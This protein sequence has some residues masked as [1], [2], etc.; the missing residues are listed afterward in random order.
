MI[1]TILHCLLWA[2]KL[3][4]D[5]ADIPR[6]NKS[7]L[8]KIYEC[9]NKSMALLHGSMF[10]Q[11]ISNLLDQQANNEK[12]QRKT[13]E[14]FNARLKEDWTN[15]NDVSVPSSP[16]PIESNRSTLFDEDSPVSSANRSIIRHH[17]EIFNA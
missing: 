3:S 16:P 7:I 6:Y 2:N 1:Q 8:N 4:E 13:L 15:E 17:E 11:I 5:D 9:L 10:V 12:F 14:I